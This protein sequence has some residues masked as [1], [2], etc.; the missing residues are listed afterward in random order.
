[1]IIFTEKYL[2]RFIKLNIDF[3]VGQIFDRIKLIKKNKIISLEE[4]NIR[5]MTAKIPEN[6]TIV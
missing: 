4:V 2:E 3:E 1:M 5:G 6:P